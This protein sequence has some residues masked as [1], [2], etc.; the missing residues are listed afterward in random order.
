EVHR[1]YLATGHEF[2]EDAF[3]RVSAAMDAYSERMRARALDAC[4][5]TRV[6]H[7]QPAEV[8]D[9]QLRCVATRR[10]QA[11]ALLQQLTHVD[12]LMVARGPLLMTGLG[13][14]DEC[15]D[16]KSLVGRAAARRA[17]PP[18]MRDQVEK[19]LAA[20][21]SIHDVGH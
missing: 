11:A 12:R 6:R 1:A 13:D 3:S 18:V 8:M 5:A 10:E 19:G 9:L 16:A 17:A 21:A 14:P 15:R 2:A 7:T 20:L 4:E